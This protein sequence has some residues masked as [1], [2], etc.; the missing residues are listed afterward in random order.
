MSRAYF[1]FLLHYAIAIYQRYSE[2]DRQKHKR[3]VFSISATCYAI[4]AAY[5]DKIN[6]NVPN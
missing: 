5:R 6:Q 2:T 3:H 1:H 4:I